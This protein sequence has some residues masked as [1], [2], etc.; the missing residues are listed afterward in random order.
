MY[1]TR[2]GDTGTTTVYGCNQRLSKSSAIAE[3]L[4]ALDEATSFLG[5][6]RAR[7]EKVLMPEGV[8]VAVRIEEIQ[9]H[10]FTIQAELAGAEKH[11]TDDAVSELE[12]HIDALARVIPPITTFIVPGGSESSALAD[13]ARTIVRRAE[14]RVVAVV[15]EGIVIPAPATLAYLNRLSSFLFILARYVNKE[16]G[17][18][19]YAPAYDK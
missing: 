14:R 1:Y 4:G 13:M 9:N 18:D 5:L 11:L 16:A 12:R 17:V 19:E 7:T 2:V 3:A 6:L 15:E 10:L 8:S